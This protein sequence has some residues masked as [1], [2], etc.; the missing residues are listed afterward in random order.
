MLEGTGVTEEMYR[1]KRL[2]MIR[3]GVSGD[4]AAMEFFHLTKT[5]WHSEDEV[6]CPDAEPTLA[7]LKRR[8]FKLGVIANQNPG[9]EERLAAW[10]LLGFFDVVASSAELGVAKPDPG[11]FRWALK[12]AECAARNAIMIGDRLDNDIAP[13]NRLGMHTVRLMRGI[14]AYHEPLT[15]DE[16]PEYTIRSLDELL[17]LL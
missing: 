12:Q 14:S 16:Q 13:A 6:P 3:K 4:Q 8:G 17:S 2:E 1:E 10:G 11:I 9:T 15:A 7:E 5:P